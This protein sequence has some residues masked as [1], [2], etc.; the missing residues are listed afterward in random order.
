MMEDCFM[1]SS[2]HANAA[3]GP[4]EFDLELQIAAISRKVREVQWARIV[5]GV[6]GDLCH[7]RRSQEYLPGEIDLQRRPY[8]KRVAV[9]SLKRQAVISPIIF[10][11]GAHRKSRCDAVGEPQPHAGRR[12]T[13]P[14]AGIGGFG[15]LRD[16]K[17]T[18][19]NSS[20]LGI[21]YAVF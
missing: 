20:H 10:R 15:D 14:H 7:K 12:T 5:N 18:R 6:A 17:S 11:R 2:Y 8:K 1:P 16:R 21:S 19:L 13:F 3:R 4:L 9:E